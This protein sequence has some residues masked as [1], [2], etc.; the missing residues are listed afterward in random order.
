MELWDALKTPMIVSV[1]LSWLGAL[2]ACLPT[3]GLGFSLA[4][5]VQ[6]RN[7]VIAGLL[8]GIAGE[9][10]SVHWF[11]LSLW[12]WCRNQPQPCSDP[13][14]DVALI[15]LIP[16]G[17]C[18]GSLLALIWTWLTLKIPERSAWSAVCV[19]SGPSRVR[20][21]SCAIVRQLSFWPLMMWLIYGL[22][23]Q[24]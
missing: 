14:G 12:S 7:Y 13:R 3:L 2:I 11:F 21:W 16:L 19:Y 4:P 17:A 15:Y 23:A 22:V 1:E 18:C 24:V 9:F 6:R 8:G 5:P 20:N 10:C